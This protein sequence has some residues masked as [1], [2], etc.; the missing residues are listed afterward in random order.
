MM[1]HSNP[2][3]LHSEFKV[4]LC[5]VRPCSKNKEEE[6]LLTIHDAL[7]SSP[8]INKIKSD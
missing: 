7:G 5:Q 2:G 1:R 6:H 4:H 8:R 3:Q